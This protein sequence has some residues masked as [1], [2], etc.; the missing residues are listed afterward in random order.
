M[1]EKNEQFVINFEKHSYGGDS[2][3]HTPDG[4]AIFAPYVLPGET[5]IVKPYF[6][7]KRFI[8]ASLVSIEKKAN[9]RIE[10]VCPYFSICGGCHYQNLAYENQLL[11][12]QDIVMEQLKRIGGLSNPPVKPIIASENQ[13]NYRNSIQFHV[14]ENGELGFQASGGREIVPVSECHLPK[15]GIIQ[16]WKTLDLDSFPGLQRVQFRE[17]VENDLMM[18]LESE[19][20]QTLPEMELDIPVSVIHL[21]PGGTI[22]MAGDDHLVYE[23]NQRLFRVSSTSFFQVNIGQAEKMVAKVISL[24]KGKGKNLLELYCGV[25]L[26]TAFLAPFFEEIVAV[27]ESESACEDF[28]INLDEYE[29]I[30]LY[31]GPVEN[32]VSQLEFQPD[33]VLVD[34]PRSGLDL[35]VF[36]SIKK[37]NISYLVYVSCDTATFARDTKRLISEGFDLEEVTPL[38][39]FPQTYHIEQIALF[40][41]K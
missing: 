13:F 23:V 20:S 5:A 41:K 38:D 35:K 16:L 21:S 12:K 34:P 26:F 15:D 30:S 24:F 31:M 9:N 14:N 36:D 3:G 6:V 2:I 8:K 11:L 39:M 40:S 33:C 27:E 29:N 17:G 7:K 32:I 18:V 19:D 22:V 4:R 37:L 1:T 25:G 28:A 10:P